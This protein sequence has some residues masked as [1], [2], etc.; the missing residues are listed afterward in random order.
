MSSTKMNLPIV[1]ELTQD[2]LELFRKGH[3]YALQRGFTNE[4]VIEK[5]LA[6]EAQFRLKLRF[7]WQLSEKAGSNVSRSILLSD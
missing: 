4:T 1:F 7:D 2:E 6:E 5:W 3:E